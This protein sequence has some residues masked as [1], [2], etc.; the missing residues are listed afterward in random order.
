VIKSQTS[1]DGYW[2]VKPEKRVSGVSGVNIKI[3]E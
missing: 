3:D 2:I 1:T